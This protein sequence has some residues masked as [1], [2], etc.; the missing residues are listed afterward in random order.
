MTTY[1][2]TD[3]LSLDISAEYLGIPPETLRSLMA[4]E[5][6]FPV[7]LAPGKIP[8]F[9]VRDLRLLRDRIKQGAPKIDP[10]RDR[11]RT[12]H[13]ALK[14]I[15]TRTT[16]KLKA[17]QEECTHPMAEKINRADTGNYDPSQDSYWR[18]CTCPDCGKF[19]K[20]DQK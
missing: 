14:R 20:E 9:L 8:I 5:W 1:F 10:V 15:M 11:I 2:D 18:D 19:W 3:K 12:R 16:D 17:L 4:C 6:I 13:S 7:S